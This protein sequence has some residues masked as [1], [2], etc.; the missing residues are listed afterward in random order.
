MGTSW[1]TEMREEMKFALLCYGSSKVRYNVRRILIPCVSQKDLESLVQHLKIFRRSE[2]LRR[3][4]VQVQVHPRVVH[5]Q[6]VHLH[7]V[8]VHLVHHHHQQPSLKA[9]C[10]SA[11]AESHCPLPQDRSLPQIQVQLKIHMLDL[12]HLHL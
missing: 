4:Q 10:L 9:L 7:P 3:P 2:N 11:E 8:V 12:E 5:P 1:L 6:V